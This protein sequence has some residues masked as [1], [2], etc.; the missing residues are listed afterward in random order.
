L[1]VSGTAMISGIIL[2]TVMIRRRLYREMG[3]TSFRL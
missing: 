2:W 1:T 3:A